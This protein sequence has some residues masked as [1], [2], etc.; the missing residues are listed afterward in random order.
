MFTREIREISR[1]ICIKQEKKIQFT[2]QGLLEHA[3]QRFDLIWRRPGVVVHHVHQT[4]DVG[5]AVVVALQAQRSGIFDLLL[6]HVVLHRV[7]VT[8]DDGVHGSHLID[9][10]LRALQERFRRLERDP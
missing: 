4:A 1:K 7:G 2:H 3:H 5:L 6:V 9:K 10:L 8:G